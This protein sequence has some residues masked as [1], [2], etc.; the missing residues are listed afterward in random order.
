MKN[1]VVIS[2]LFGVI[3]VAVGVA[4]YLIL[5][6]KG[7]YIHN[8]GEAQGTIYSATYE[9][10]E[11]KD[12][13]DKIEK[14]IHEFD[15]SIS[16][17]DP[18]SVISRINRNDP[19]VKTDV[20]FET[21]FYSAQEA[22][23]RTN[24]AIDITVG[25]LVK[26]WG[27]FNFGMNRLNKF[28]NVSEFLPYVGYKK[29]H[30]KDHKL[31]KD[32]PRIMI[33]DNSLGEGYSSDIVAELLKE[34]GCKNYMVDIGGEVVCK[35]LNSKGEKWTIGIN[36][37]I[38]DSTSTISKIQT[39]IHITNC[40]VT[41]SGGYRKFFIRNG[42][43]YSHIINPHTGYP[44]DNN[45]LSVTVVAP[46]GLMADTYDTPFMVIGV[47]SCLKVCKRIPGMDC[48]IIYTGKDGKNQVV[49]TDGFKKYLTK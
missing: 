8:E 16:T 28:P 27:F 26:A 22:A 36:K 32:D 11:G 44:I 46:T 37:P 48:Y 14:K 35:G 2:L 29:I 38:D 1:K 23:R 9:E 43:K 40:A 17:Y 42:K 39:V 12:L 4:F 45:M 13:Q 19:T 31:I 21:M 49:Y 10:P 6:T 41:T 25:P 3:F 15:K 47:D 20:Y 7:E 30:I 33:D 5:K 24:G 34:N 18:N